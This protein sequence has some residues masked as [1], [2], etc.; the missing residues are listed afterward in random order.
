MG[1]AG[2]L[3]ENLLPGVGSVEEIL[4]SEAHA[5]GARFQQVVLT[6]N[7]RVMV[8]VGDGG[9]TL[10]VHEVFSGASPEVLRAVARMYGRGRPAGRMAAREVVREFIRTNPAAVATP[11]RP[12][13]PRGLAPGDAERIERLRAEFDRVNAAYFD[14]ALPPVPIALSGRMRRRNGHFSTHPLEIVVSRR[15]FTEAAEGEAEHTL[16]HEMIHLWQHHTGAKPGHGADFRQWA[17]RLG[18]HPRARRVVQNL[19][20]TSALL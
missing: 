9:R 8:S 17:R 12:P 10:R 5:A 7:R 2:A 19:A 3:A 18:V 20:R 11:V 6:R 1:G 13:R 14:G 4:L 16:R 15:L